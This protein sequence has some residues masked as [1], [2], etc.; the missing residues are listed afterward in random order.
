MPA[1]KPPRRSAGLLLYRRTAAGSFEVFLAHPG[2]PYWTSK[3]LGHWTIPKGEPDPDEPLLDAALREFA[4]ETGLPAPP[5]PY[6]DL[7]HIVQK[8]GKHVHAWAA[9]GDADPALVRSNTCR[10][11]WPPRSRRLIEVPEIDRCAWFDPDEARRRIKETQIPLI[12]RL[13]EALARSP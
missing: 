7:G 12:D 11:E 2:G 5:G 10:I 3:D 8:G 13:A 9:A 1:K 4:E 6:L